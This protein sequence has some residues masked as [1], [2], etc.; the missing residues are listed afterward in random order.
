MRER[1]LTEIINDNFLGGQNSSEHKNEAILFFARY[2]GI[3]KEMATSGTNHCLI[4]DLEI[5]LCKLILS[6][7]LFDQVTVDVLTKVH[8]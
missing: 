6:Y 7:D 3:L 2:V 5:E 8:Q 4:S 1:N